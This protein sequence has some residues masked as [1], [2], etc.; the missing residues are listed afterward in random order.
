VQKRTQLKSWPANYNQTQKQMSKKPN[1]ET[2]RTE[3]TWSAAMGSAEYAWGTMPTINGWQDVATDMRD[4][5]RRLELDLDH[6]KKTYAR[7]LR[8]R[9]EFERD[10]VSMLIDRDSWEKQNEQSVADAVRY[11]E[12][13]VVLRRHL[14]LVGETY[15]GDVA[16]Q[17][18][19]LANTKV[20]P[21]K[22]DIR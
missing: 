6:Y 1:S 9:T 17:A 14:A 3:T 18:S 7:S 4:L 5:A 10:L 19:R 12:E 15:A 2:P 16:E 11:L 22:Y 20:E 8:H 21:K 13:N